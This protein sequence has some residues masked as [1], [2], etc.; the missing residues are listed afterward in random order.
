M[1]ALRLKSKPGKNS[2]VLQHILGYF[3]KNLS[4]EEKRELLEI[5]QHYREGL[6]PLIV[7]LTLGN[8]Y[9]RKYDQ[10]YLKTQTYLNPHPIEL[11]LRNHV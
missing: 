5:V 8:H 9:V 11:Q 1:A 4:A 6:I 2:N 7:P 10:P 3:K